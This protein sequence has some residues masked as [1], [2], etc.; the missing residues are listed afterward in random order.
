[1][2]NAEQEQYLI[3]GLV[4]LGNMAN[5]FDFSKLDD[6]DYRRIIQAIDDAIYYIEDNCSHLNWNV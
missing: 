1:M 4:D 6:F 2:I 3:D 5:E